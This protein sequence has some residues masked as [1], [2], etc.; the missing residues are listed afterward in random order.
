MEL[1]RNAAQNGWR[2]Y[3]AAARQPIHMLVMLS[4][5]M[6][7]VEIGGNF[8]QVPGNPYR[9][10]VA[11]GLIE[12]LLSVTGA[13][14]TLLAPAALLAALL[15]LTWRSGRW[16][17]RPAVP[18][19]MLVEAAVTAIPLMVLARVLGPLAVAGGLPV[20]R[21]CDGIGAGLYE[22]LVFRLFLISALLLVAE[23]W[24]SRA[25]AGTVRGVAVLLAGV[26]FSWVHFQPIGGE[27]F[28][29]ALFLSRSI[30]GSYLGF[31]FVHRGFGIAAG[32]HAAYNA[33][34]ILAMQTPPG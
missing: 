16:R 28:D 8:A 31:I 6:V 27:V 21:L 13:A 1:A 9:S 4:P 5:L 7:A 32:S 2:G 22:E 15:S 25:R 34:T 12:T 33:F 19:L 11:R 29:W 24:L 10:H 26:A 20:A 30:A 18:A 17:V 3:L 14:G 23:T